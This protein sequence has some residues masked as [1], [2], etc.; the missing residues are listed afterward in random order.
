[1][2]NNREDKNKKDEAVDLEKDLD[3]NEEGISNKSL[4]RKSKYDTDV[5]FS[6]FQG[7]ES[8]H[9]IKYYTVKSAKDYED[10]I[11]E[12]MGAKYNSVYAEKR[13]TWKKVGKV[14]IYRDEKDFQKTIDE[15][16]LAII[17]SLL[18]EVTEL[19]KI[20]KQYYFSKKIETVIKLT[21]L[22]EEMYLKTEYVMSDVIYVDEYSVSR[23]S[24]GKF[25]LRVS[26]KMIAPFP[27]EFV[28]HHGALAKWY[29]KRGWKRHFEQ[30]KMGVLQG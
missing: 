27:V 25:I 30:I 4:N 17:S 2:S 19:E 11:E 15:L 22:P 21:Y 6:N 23:N 12:L 26:K 16:H 7:V 24:K 5:E 3:V 10:V 20:T 28:S 13:R 1:M 14:S 9:K 29:L 8:H 18:K